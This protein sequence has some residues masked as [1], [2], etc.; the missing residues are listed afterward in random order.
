M[1]VVLE[2]IKVQSPPFLRKQLA[3]TGGI[4][5]ITALMFTLISL[6]IVMS[7][8]Y[9]ITQS[10]KVSSSTK[11]Y[12][13]SIDA[14]YGGA[15]LFA[16]D[17]IPFL[18]QNVANTSLAA[19]IGTTY[20]NAVIGT[21]GGAADVACLQWKLTHPSST[22]VGAGCN[23]SS[24]T[25]SPTDHPDLTFKVLSTNGSPFTIYA[26]IV[27]TTAGN[28]DVSGLQLD[29]SGVAEAGTAITPMH[30]PF[31]YRIEVQG[32]QSTTSERANIEVLYAY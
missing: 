7:L 1:R 14:S 16:Q 27:E 15:E 22:W 25:P 9:I 2:K 12:K 17:M 13:T 29:G 18:M 6:T 20:T 19:L 30:N 3:D 31:V 24:N 11:R 23:S 8:M 32:Q 28:T 21:S 5:L 26:K 10:I 4:A